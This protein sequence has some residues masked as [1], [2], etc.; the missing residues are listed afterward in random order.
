MNNKVIIWGVDDYNT[1]ALIRQVGQL[2]C[3]VHFL[4]IGKAK[5]AAYS[6]YCT[7]YVESSNIENGFDILV[8]NYANEPKR[9]IIITNG[10]D[11]ITFIDKHRLELEKLFILPGCRTQGD[12]EYYIDKYNM[13]NLAEQCGIDVPKSWFINKSSSIDNIIYP[14]FI[15]PSHQKPGHYNEFKFKLCK[16]KSDLVNTLRY[17]REDSVFIVQQYIEREKDLLVYGCRM[18]DGKIEIAGGLVTDRFAVG[19]GSSYGMVSSTAHPS[20]DCDKIRLFLD[21][22]DYVGLFSFEY[23]LM[24]GVAYFFEINM[25]NDGTSHFFFD[26]GANLPGAYVLASS[27]KS[28]SNCS[29][30]VQKQCT[31]MDDIYDISNVVLGNVTMSQWKVQRQSIGAYKFYNEDDPQPYDIAR[32][33]KWLRII[34]DIILKKFRVYVL[35]VLDRL[36]FRK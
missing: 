29:V 17:V 11:V 10:D 14:C 4:V 35:F 23:G 1:L 30:K 31:Y 7:L 19:Q 2:A 12:T 28:Y 8:N 15:K 3:D 18:P 6:K 36:G 22:I 25:R 21:K 13:T 34:R 32:K 5:Y 33:G 20:I 26:A 27:G 24:N 16:N 9:P